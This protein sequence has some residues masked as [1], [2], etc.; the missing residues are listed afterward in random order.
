MNSITQLFNDLCESHIAGFLCNHGFGRRKQSKNKAKRSLKKLAYDTL[1]VHL[2]QEEVRQLQPNSSRLPV[3]NKMLMLSFNLRMCGMSSEAD[4]LE[5]LVEHLEKLNG[6]QVGDA[7][8]VLE[9]LIDLAGTGPPQVLPPKRDLFQNNKY[10]GRK[11]CYSG[12]DYYDVRVFEADLGTF[13]AHQECEISNTVHRTL[14]IMEGAPGAGLPAM[15]LFSQNYPI[16]DRFEK[17]TRVSLF[18]AL[19][20]SRT[21]DMDIKLDFPPVPDSADVSGLAIKVPQS[22]D[23]SEDE[24]FQSASNM[25]PD[26]QSE[27]SMTPDIDLWEAVLTYGPSKR[28]CWE[29]IGCPPGKREDPYFTEAGRE[30]FD[31]LYK[32]H[33]GALQIL[34]NTGLQ[35]P[36]LVML[37]ESELVNDVL[38]ALIG[39]VSTTF[40]F[41]QSLQAF[42]VKQGI[43]MSGTS[44]DNISNLL[45]QIGEY[46]TFYIRLSHFSLRTVLDSSH[47]KGIVFQA[48]TSGLRKY[49][50]YY[51]AC[52]LSTPATLSLLTISFL[53]RKL[54][55]QLRYLAELC[56]VG[57]LC[58]GA[59]RGNNTLFPTGVKLL[60]YLY[61]EALE[62]S[63]NENYPVL[64]SLLKTSCEPYTRFIYDWVYSGVF[65]DVCGEFMIRVNEDFLGFRD[66]RY[67]THGYSLISKDV[68]DC[69]PVFLKHLANE[70]YVCGK[71]IN[72]LKLCCPKHYICWSDIP[73]PRICITFSLEELK[74]MEKDCAV[75]VARMER[76]ARYSSISREEKN[77]QAEIAKHELIIQARAATEKILETFKDQKLAERAYLDTKKRE[78]FQKL[79]DQYEK[80]QERRLAVKQEEADDDFSYARE[81]RDREQR[82]KALE[83][84]LEAKAKQELIEHYSR[85]S[86]EATRKEQKALWKLQRHRLE[87]TR[88]N[89]F[90]EEEKQLQ[91]LLAQNPVGAP[92]EKMDNSPL[93][94]TKEDCPENTSP[95]CG[96]QVGFVFRNMYSRYLYLHLGSSGARHK[97]SSDLTPNNGEILI[98]ENKEILTLLSQQEN[99]CLPSEC[100]SGGGNIGPSLDRHSF[101][102]SLCTPDVDIADFLPRSPNVT[103]Q[104]ELNV[105]QSLVEDALKYIGSEITNATETPDSQPVS[106]S[107]VPETR[108]L[109]SLSENVYDFN[110]VLNPV[111]FTRLS[112]ESIKVGEDVSN[113]QHSRPRWHIHGHAS[114]SAIKIGDYVPDIKVFHHQASAY[115]H[116]SDSHM[117][118]GEYVSDVDPGQPQCNIHGHVSSGHIKVG[119]YASDVESKLPR[120]NIHGHASQGN[121]KVGENVSD[122]KPSRPRWNIHGHA[123]DANIKIGENVSE[124]ESLRP[125]WNIH[126]HASQSHIQVGEYVS[127]VEPGK[128]R[129]SAFG[130]VSHSSIEEGYSS[131]IH[132]KGV[133]KSEFGHSSDSTVQYLMYGKKS[134][135]NKIIENKSKG[136]DGA[137]EQT[138]EH[139]DSSDA[140]TVLSPS[141]EEDEAEDIA[142][143]MIENPNEG[144]VPVSSSSLADGQHGASACQE[145]GPSVIE[146]NSGHPPSACNPAEE[147]ACAAD[148]TWEKEQNYLKALAAKYCLEKYQ[149][150]YEIMSEPPVSH[151][152]SHIMPRQF[153]FPMDPD[154]HSATDE[155]A[156]QLIELLSLPVLM[157]YSVTAPMVSHVSLVNKAIV[158]YYFV[159][160]NMEKHFEAIRHFLLME[161]GEFAQSLSDLLFEKLGSGQTP[162]VMLTPLVLN[163]ILNKA[164]QYSLHGD[165]NLASNLSFALKYLPEMFIPTAPDTLSCLELKYKIGWPLNIVITESCMNKYNKIFSFLLQLKHMVW[166]LRDV[167]FHLKRTA[168]VNKASSSVQH[169]QLQLYRH[170]MQHFVK[171]I[172][173]YIANQILHV[174]WCEFRNK[175][176]TVSNLEEIYKTHADYLNKALFRGL[177]TEK[178]A[179]LMNIIHSIFSLILKFRIQLIS[180]PWNCDKGKQM[181][182]HP[183]FGLMQQSYNTFKYYS[184][185]LF[186]VVTKLVSRGYQP[187]L[188]DFLLRI[189][190]NNYYKET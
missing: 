180:Q 107:E 183:N 9:L 136:A 1:F 31:K 88:L 61:K 156:V 175:L 173:G 141:P 7:Y 18:G 21:N 53:F 37:R 161:D 169:R 90:S 26:S 127:N 116:S 57:T 96:V 174:T 188:E 17:E 185:F 155:S 182:T 12:Y 72:L 91:V 100:A 99:L 160:L 6:A 153:A 93:V 46:G 39:V 11:P 5:E 126:G 109:S 170:E 120:K 52:V 186:E 55:R 154:I 142:V 162:S 22:I 60:S 112:Q 149:D 118:I 70:I 152:L 139:T 43:Y 69:V 3:K 59:N 25:T 82:L 111:A 51:R 63:S 148:V 50:Q 106:Q 65:R 103:Q 115:G 129:H 133:Q 4:H 23:Q 58:A 71:T 146:L 94:K 40:S 80:D 78:L 135:T 108:E 24:G 122:V 105:E 172:Q 163:S 38:N 189:N 140:V 86:E 76:I 123:S 144:Q 176:G 62:N 67:W 8:S 84:E 47:N 49:L 64:L 104:V 68:E 28:R 73:V 102:S 95:L 165:S 74:E 157:K 30:A 34:S 164:L 151:P 119:Q 134:N 83:E 177:M 114:D 56:C 132:V 87:T 124:V 35:P 125:R 42:V 98:G 167:W 130:H 138:S 89:F 117:N 145:G 41:N 33:E 81:L 147:D 178:A 181:A 166:T 92:G 2:F 77:L 190:F 19:I 159:E 29:R 143:S 128:P 187:H 14:Q 85:L 137:E 48:F 44:P 75:Y 179:P 54:G 184:D 121:I 97:Q 168:L 20:H 10:V 150:R 32:L 15:G 27:P 171:V 16:S 110:T 113:V 101:E 36:H 66:R 45:A 13:L 79:K 131:D 158:D